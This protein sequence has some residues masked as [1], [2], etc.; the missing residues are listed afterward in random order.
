[1]R[2]ISL[3]LLVILSFALA[4]CGQATPPP[5]SAEEIVARAATRM[6]GL[7]GFHFVIDSTGAPAYLDYNNTFAFRRAEGEYVSPDRAS[8]SV[9]VL[10]PGM[11]AEVQILSIGEQYWETNVFTGEWTELPAGMG[12]NP[13]V[14]F[15]PVIGF[16]PLIESDLTNLKYEGLEELKELP[17]KLLYTVSGSLLGDRLWQMSYQMIGP[18]AVTL[19]LWASPDTFEVQRVVITEPNPEKGEATIWQVDFWNFDQPAEIVPPMTPSP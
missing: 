2:R 18:E 19:K 1:M 16:Q 13:A 9:R 7:S 10:A 5:L 12:F 6:K 15:D 3:L 8:A 14:L 11:V 17:G 4:G